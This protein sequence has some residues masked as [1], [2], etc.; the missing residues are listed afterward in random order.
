MDWID[1]K[2]EAL[3]AIPKTLVG[4]HQRPIITTV[5]SLGVLDTKTLAFEVAFTPVQLG[6]IA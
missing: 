4:G 1:D 6:A 5:T 3:R 2:V